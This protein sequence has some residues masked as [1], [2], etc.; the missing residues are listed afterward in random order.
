MAHPQC[1]RTPRLRPFRTNLGYELWQGNRPESTGYFVE[2]LHPNK[3]P[4]EYARYA[5]LGELRYMQE[6]SELAHEAIRANPARFLRLSLKRIV[7]F[8]TGLGGKTTSYLQSAHMLLTTTLGLTGL[9][10]LLRRRHSSA[11]FLALPL[12][13]F[14]LPYYLTHPDPRFRLVLDPILTIL[15]AYAITALHNGWKQ[16]HAAQLS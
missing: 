3:N 12:L 10:L 5:S 16:S 9:I 2:S 4:A 1:A 13:L 7:S 11:I 8:W 15:T 6:K 14:P